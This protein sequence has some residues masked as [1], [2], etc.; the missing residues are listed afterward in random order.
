MEGNA[1]S[2]DSLIGS[3]ERTCVVSGS[4]RALKRNATSCY[5]VQ[6][7]C[8]AETSDDEADANLIEGEGEGD[9][10][11]ESEEDVRQTRQQKRARFIV[12][13]MFS[14]GLGLGADLALFQYGVLASKRPCGAPTWKEVGEESC[15]PEARA[16]EA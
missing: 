4:G 16:C 9:T 7:Y 2:I 6:E 8:E 5:N 12:D 15:A 13:D 10:D 1:E 14:G 11:G 3:L